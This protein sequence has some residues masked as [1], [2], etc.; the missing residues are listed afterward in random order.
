MRRVTTL[1]AHR[2]N[3][4]RVLTKTEGRTLFDTFEAAYHILSS[5]YRNEYFF[6][7]TIVRKIIVGRHSPKT[8]SAIME[9]PS[10]RSFADLVVANGTTTCYEIKTDLDSLA[11]LDTQIPDYMKRFEYTYVVTA[12]ASKPLAKLPKGCGII[13][14]TPRNTLSIQRKAQSNLH[15]MDHRTLLSLLRKAEALRALSGI[16]EDLHGNAK[17]TPWELLT[18]RAQELDLKTVHNLVTSALRARNPGAKAA[19]LS[20]SLPPSLSAAVYGANISQSGQ[21]RL[22]DRML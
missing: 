12:N 21:T 16:F 18:K 22:L 6:K 14:L 3:N 4:L 13:E 15:N 1:S 11:R 7:N 10:G 5:E 2:I 8:A 9:M 20:E 19:L 17:D